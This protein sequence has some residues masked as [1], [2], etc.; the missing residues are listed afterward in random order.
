MRFDPRLDAYRELGVAET[1]SAET[2]RQAYLAL[3]RRYHPDRAPDGKQSEYEERMKRI[4]SAYEIL[5]N[6]KTRALYD[7]MRQHHGQISPNPRVSMSRSVDA[8]YSPRDPYHTMRVGYQRRYY[9]VHVSTQQMPQWAR[10][11]VGVFS[12]VGLV[13]GFVLGLPFG[14]IGCIPGG[15]VGLIGGALLG[16]VAVYLSVL[17][18]P[19]FVFGWIG[20]ALLG[21]TGLWLGGTIGLALGIIAAVRLWKRATSVLRS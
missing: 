21:Q 18:V 4:N 14:I 3:A 20:Y 8:P 7:R 19:I 9:H 5:S 10:L 11:L 16:L 12:G 1:A 6:P 2:I 13:L 15:L 17:G